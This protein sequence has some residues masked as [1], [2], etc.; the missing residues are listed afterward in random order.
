MP[1]LYRK[2]IVLIHDMTVDAIFILNKILKF[3]NGSPN[4]FLNYIMHY[5]HTYLSLFVVGKIL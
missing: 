4:G 1:T 2:F 3:S 5:L